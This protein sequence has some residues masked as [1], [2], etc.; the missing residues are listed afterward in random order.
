MFGEAFTMSISKGVHRLPSRIGVLLTFLLTIILLAYT[1]FKMSIMIN[2]NDNVMT[3]IIN[4]FHYDSDYVMDRSKYLN[5]AIALSGFDK[6]QENILDPSIAEI[7]FEAHE[8]EFDAVGNIDYGFRISLESHVCSRD[9]LGL[10]GS[11]GRFFP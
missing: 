11:N 2:R 9:E 5:F 8:W 3:S 7:K 6:E 10:N 1:A 4:E